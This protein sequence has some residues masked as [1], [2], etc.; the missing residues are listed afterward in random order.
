MA[1]LSFEEQEKLGKNIKSIDIDKYFNE[2]AL[3]KEQKKNRIILANKLN[4]AF[5]F[6]M[7]LVD[8]ENRYGALNKDSILAAIKMRYKNVVSES[9]EIDE[10]MA[11][12]IDAL[13]EDIVDATFS[14]L[15]NIYTVSEDRARYIAENEANTLF[16]VFEYKQA[17]LS[18]KTKKR[19]KSANDRFVRD[20]HDVANNKEVGIDSPFTIGDSLMMFPKDYSLGA[21]AKE[22]VNCRCCVRYF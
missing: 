8:I 22:I 3:D 5:L 11:Q 16:N 18:G 17:K 21:D 15:T 7:Y 9:L 20:T 2:M 10:E 1:V 14:N 12:Y 13:C 6:F 4:E 19:W